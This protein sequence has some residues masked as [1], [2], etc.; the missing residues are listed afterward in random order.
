MCNMHLNYK[1]FIEWLLGS[2]GKVLL[3]DMFSEYKA[4]L[5]GACF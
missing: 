3:E 5:S 1:A 2:K 4:R